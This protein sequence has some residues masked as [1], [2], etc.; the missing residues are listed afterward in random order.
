MF[1]FYSFKK[2][3][4][5]DNTGLFTENSPFFFSLCIHINWRSSSTGEINLSFV[6]PHNPIH[7]TTLTAY[8]LLSTVYMVSSLCPLVFLLPLEQTQA[9]I[10]ND[11]KWKLDL[12]ASHIAW[13]NHWGK[14]A[15]L[16]E[17]PNKIFCCVIDSFVESLYLVLYAV[18]IYFL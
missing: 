13:L 18:S 10:I 15:S 4:T 16:Y 3:S 2:L 7:L 17:K 9:Y 8:S 12:N 6:T 5:A 1:L 11:D 14:T